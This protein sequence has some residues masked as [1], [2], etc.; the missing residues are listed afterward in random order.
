MNAG[1]RDA[2]SLARA[3]A[4]ATRSADRVD[5]VIAP[6]FTALAAVAHEV[7]EVRGSIDVTEGFGV[8]VAGQNM[9]AQ[10]VGAFTGEVSAPMLLDAGATWVILGHSERRQFFG[11]TDDG[12]ASKV[13]AA[14]AAAIRPIACVGETLAEREA[15]QTLVVVE[16]QVRAFMQLFAEAPGFGVIAYEPVWAIGTGKVAKP[17]DAQDV[18]AQIREL[19]LEINE[20]VAEATRI[21][22]GGSVKA[23]NAPGLFEQEDIDGALVGGASLD[24]EGFAKIVEAA[25]SIAARFASPSPGMDEDDAADLRESSASGRARGLA[26]STTDEVPASRGHRAKVKSVANDGDDE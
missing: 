11:E 4:E 5:V 14:I 20:E 7:Q 26:R 6:P 25:Q 12:V 17:A 23:D 13:K 2:C 19:L 24:A 18:H 22:Y 8:G 9:Y 10:P 3:V 1:G 15:G 16:R 21:L